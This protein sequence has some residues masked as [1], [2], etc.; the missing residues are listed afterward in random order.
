[1]SAFELLQRREIE[2]VDSGVALISHRDEV[3]RH[4]EIKEAMIENL[5]ND[6]RDPSESIG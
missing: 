2:A 1:M 4:G 5:K 3:I 6:D